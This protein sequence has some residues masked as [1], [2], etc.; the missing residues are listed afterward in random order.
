MLAHSGPTRTCRPCSGPTSGLDWKVGSAQS[1]YWSLIRAGVRRQRLSLRPSASVT[2][3]C[4]QDMSLPRICQPCMP[5]QTFSSFLRDTRDFDCHCWKRWLVEH[6]SSFRTD[7][8]AKS[9][10]SP[11]QDGKVCYAIQ[12][13]Q[14]R[15]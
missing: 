13:W 2:I 9:L 14:I 12:G 4:L 3:L 5:E 1:L 8:L 11:M 15:S 6:Q 10:V 7:E